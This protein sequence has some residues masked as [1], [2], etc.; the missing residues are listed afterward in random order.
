MHFIPY[1]RQ[2]INQDDVQRVIGVLE[3]DWLTQGP[4]IAAFEEAV[5]TY[6]GTKYAVAIN[7]ATSGLHI[8]CMALNLGPGDSLWTSPNTFVSSANCARYCGAS[9]DFVDIDPQTYNMS[10]PALEAKLKLARKEGTLPRVVVPVHF[11]GQSCDMVG[12]H[13]LSKEYGFHVLEDAAHAI[14]G[15]YLNEPIGSCRY[16]DMTVFSFHPVKIITTAE[17]G[18]VL[19]NREDLYQKLTR[20]RSHGITRDPE[21]LQEP[22][23]GPWYYEQQALGLNYRM[24]DLQAALGLS[25]LSRLDAF[26]EQR[27]FLARRYETLLSGFPLQLPWQ[28][29]DTSSSFHLYV[30][31]LNP[32][33]C[34]KEIFESLRAANIGVQV[35]YIPVHTQPYYQSLGFRPGDYPQA[36]TYYAQAIS[37]PMFATLSESEQDYVVASLDNALVTHAPETKRMNGY[38]HFLQG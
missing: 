19:T 20:L 29:P 35:H 7:S 3:S 23:H 27:R 14:G 34:R 4:A 28:H 9:V 10:L 25:Q 26:V 18:M 30:I 22:A 38:E 17:G 13:E 8:A 31:R 33:I 1:G 11:A 37:L 2:S 15:R 16:S 21:W 12:I 6:C 5:A 36:E 24:T 32:D